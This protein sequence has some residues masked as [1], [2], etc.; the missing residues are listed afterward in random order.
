MTKRNKLNRQ[1]T[2]CTTI[3]W[4]STSRQSP[5]LIFCPPRGTAELTG[6]SAEYLHHLGVATDVRPAAVALAEVL[7]HLT[8]SVAGNVLTQ[9]LNDLRRVRLG[10]LKTG[11]VRVTGRFKASRRVQ[12]EA[13]HETMVE[14][15]AGEFRRPSAGRVCVIAL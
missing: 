8:L 4:R 10:V 11:R 14:I 15:S 12:G 5:V 13:N 1:T 6:V 3:T 7:V 2:K 9:F